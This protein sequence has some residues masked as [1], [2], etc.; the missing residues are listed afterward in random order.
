MTVAWLGF[1]TYF[2][3][4]VALVFIG[5]PLCERKLTAQTISD[6][7]IHSLL[8]QSGPEDD[9]HRHASHAMKRRGGR[10]E[11]AAA[12]NDQRW[13]RILAR[14]KLILMWPWTI[15]RQRASET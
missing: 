3:P 15:R 4:L 13:G 8:E 6:E 9:L 2:W 14:Y 12:W 7:E 11:C 1:L 10:R 5:V